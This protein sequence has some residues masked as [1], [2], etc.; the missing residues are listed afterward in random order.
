MDERVKEHAKILCDWSTEIKEGDNVLIRADGQARELVIALYKEIG[1]REANPV[2][3]FSNQEASRAFL[4][5]KTKFET[6]KHLEAI[7]E[8]TDALINIKSSE[9]LRTLNNVS[10]KKLTSLSK[11]MKPI[12]DLVED[13]RWVLTQHPTNAQ[14]Q[15]A[16][17]SLEEYEDFVY[18]AIL[19]DWEKI[20]EKQQKLVDKLKEG[21]EAK[22][23]G[24]R[25]ELEMSIKETNPRNSSGKKNMPSGEVFTAP[26]YDS[27]EGVIF[28]DLPM[29]Y[30]G[31]EIEEVE[32]EFEDGEVIDF[33]AKE[34]EEY[35]EEIINVDE[36]SKR[37]G[38]LGIGTNRGITKFTKNILFDEKIGD[39]IHLALGKAIK[40]TP[41]ENNKRN[42]SAIHVDMIKNMKNSSLLVDEE[43]I[44]SEGSF[45]WEK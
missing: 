31:K 32:L 9:N 16:E 15:M 18:G 29:I 11:S 7:Y 2:T 17:M 12:Q 21:N 34:G 8:K 41:G 44:L 42:E 28:F 6:P 30:Q 27:V 35:L 14:A 4:N 5:Q 13:K 33:E 43:E 37:I 24:E 19:R 20:R 38:E 22:V 45:F 23:I 10:N 25:T 36:G 26:V 1:K 40:G 39:T 3:L